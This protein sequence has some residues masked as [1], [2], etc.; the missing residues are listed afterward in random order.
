M[1]DAERPELLILFASIGSGHEMAAAAIAEQIGALSGSRLRVR[2]LDLMGFAR[3]PRKRRLSAVPSMPGIG[4]LYDAA[5]SA[6]PLAGG[7]ASLVRLGA[8]WLLPHAAQQIECGARV[9]VSTH[10]LGAI[11]TAKM[12]GLRRVS[13]LTDLMPHAFWPREAEV[14][15]V[16]TPEARAALLA[17]GFAA[18]QIAVTGIPVRAQFS[19]LPPSGQAKVRLGLPA[20]RPI[21]LVAAGADDPGPYRQVARRLTGILSALLEVGLMPLVLTGNDVELREHV[22]ARFGPRIVA[23]PFSDD[24][25]TPMAAADVVVAKPGGLLIAECLACGKPLVL[26]ARG[27]GQERANSEYLEAHDAAIIAETE[28][29]LAE[30]LASALDGG[31][32]PMAQRAATLGLPDAARSI[33]ERAIALLERG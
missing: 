3:V 16:P 4:A 2:A 19:H 1:V 18:E 22:T 7:V 29:E 12:P 24:V 5:W 8:P 20:D 21:A 9:V 27:S 25:A 23:R 6:R 28:R 13:V 11:L 32:G 15:C 30:K 33:A 17:R 14:T 26:L 10:A 31:L